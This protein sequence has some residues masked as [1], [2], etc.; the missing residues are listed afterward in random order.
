MEPSAIGKNTMDTI[1]MEH[2]N[3]CKKNGN[4]KLN[5]VQFVS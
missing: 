4:L 1:K 3:T 5:N 2:N